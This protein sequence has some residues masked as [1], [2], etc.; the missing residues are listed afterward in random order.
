M[1]EEKL[2]RTGA[3][4]LLGVSG[5]DQV[6]RMLKNVS[7]HLSERINAII[8]STNESGIGV[9]S[10]SVTWVMDEFDKDH[11]PDSTIGHFN[12]GWSPLSDRG[13]H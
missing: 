9:D 3:I 7:M 6:D 8:T 2:P 4:C 13:I 12:I 1:S 11:N 10:I 5:I